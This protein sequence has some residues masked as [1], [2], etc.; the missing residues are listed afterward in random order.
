[1]KRLLLVLFASFF[2]AN[3]EVVA[4]GYANFT[5]PEG[6]EVSSGVAMNFETLFDLI[7]DVSIE[8]SETSTTL[9][10]TT[11]PISPPT[12]APII[13]VTPTITE[14][15][16]GPTSLL[17]QID[18]FHDDLL[19]PEIPPSTNAP[20]EPSSGS[21]ISGFSTC[22]SIWTTLLSSLIVVFAAI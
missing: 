21:T 18:N 22:S 17:D 6:I 16:A 15:P 3:T 10:P 20:S 19:P 14:A 4:Y 9:S 12:P 2:A 8:E 1:M 7:E 5:S 11:A 13:V